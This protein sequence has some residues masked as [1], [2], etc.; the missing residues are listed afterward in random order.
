MNQIEK[1]DVEEIIKG[2]DINKVLNK[3]FLITGATGAVARYIVLTLM[4]V[5][6]RYKEKA[7]TVIIYC[8][9]REKA[10]CIFKEY[11]SDPHFILM[12]GKVEEKIQ[13]EG[14]IDYI[15]HAACNS[16]TAFFKTNP[17]DVISANVIGTNNLLLLA[18]EKNVKGFLFFSSGAVYG[19]R[20]EDDFSYNGIDPLN[21]QNCYALSKQ[22][23]ENLCVSF[24]KQYG[25]L[26][27]I[28]RIG[29]TYGPHIDLEDGH[30]Y[31]DFVKAIFQGKDLVI[32]GDGQSYIGLC[33][34]TDA[35]RAF[36][37]ILFVGGANRPY[38]MRNSKEYMSIEMLAEK[39]TTCAFPEK[40]LGYK[41]AVKAKNP[42]ALNIARPPILLGELDFEPEVNIIDG[43]KKIIS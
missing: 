33:Y 22:M 13:Y 6:F 42:G 19:G 2:I 27:K 4:E 20:T 12:I 14:S 17:V 15:L 37:K 3:T 5:A 1:K 25:I 16:A 10:E 41:C 21:Y 43:F 39:L 28:V 29:Y 40:K 36:F 34:I 24:F 35:I 9:S 23:G 30:L 32:K 7:C 11:L 38:V 31:S 8:R 26:A 18:K